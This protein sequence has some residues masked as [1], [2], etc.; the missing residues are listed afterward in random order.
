[1]KDIQKHLPWIWVM[2][3]EYDLDSLGTNRLSV[4]KI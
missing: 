4:R 2:Y 3:Q 1:M